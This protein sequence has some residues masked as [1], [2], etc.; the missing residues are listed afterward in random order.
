MTF[1]A[2]ADGVIERTLHY[3]R[4]VEAFATVGCKAEEVANRV[5]EAWEAAWREEK[6]AVSTTAYLENVFLS[7]LLS[8]SSCPRTGFRAALGGFFLT[9]IWSLASVNLGEIPAFFGL[10]VSSVSSTL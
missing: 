6:F 7:Y 2:E 8:R 10:C 1:S 3:G 4:K 5:E 9:A